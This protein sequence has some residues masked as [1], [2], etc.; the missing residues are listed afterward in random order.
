[1]GSLRRL[2]SPIK[3]QMSRKARG[4]VTFPRACTTAAQARAQ[5][6]A[7]RAY[8]PHVFALVITGPPGAGKSEVAAALHDSLGDAGGD[9]ALVEVDELGRS[10]PPI[11]R[12]RSLA[13]LR[14]L[15]G[16]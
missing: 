14:M 6:A 8:S 10:Y 7:H 3:T 13:H 5:T 12:E 4:G 1:M 15:A 16:S 2:A 11:E 9:A